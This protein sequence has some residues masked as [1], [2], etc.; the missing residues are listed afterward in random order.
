MKSAAVKSWLESCF[1]F[2][3]SL[4][5]RTNITSVT[6]EN[7]WHDVIWYNI[8]LRIFHI[9]TRC[10]STRQTETMW[11]ITYGC[12]I[13]HFWI[14]WQYIIILHIWWCVPM[15]AD[16]VA[17][18]IAAT[19]DLFTW[20]QTLSIDVSLYPNFTF[21]VQPFQVT[22]GIFQEHLHTYTERH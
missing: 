9:S 15:W 13:A 5:K 4:R 2:S 17:Q 1:T 11:Y 20:T 19:L 6:A 7:I 8:N 14:L 16:F 21:T 18:R 12:D 3:T 10:K 22:Q